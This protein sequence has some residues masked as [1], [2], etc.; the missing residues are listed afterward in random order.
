VT[1]T[2]NFENWCV[3]CIRSRILVEDPIYRIPRSQSPEAFE[4]NYLTSNLFAVANSGSKT[5][6][7]NYLTA[8]MTS[9][10]RDRNRGTPST[11]V[12]G[13]LHTPTAHHRD[14]KD[15]H[16]RGTR[17]AP[18]TNPLRPRNVHHASFGA[19]A[20]RGL[21]VSNAGP[22]T[23]DAY[24]Q[25]HGNHVLSGNNYTYGMGGT[26]S[27]NGRAGHGNR[28]TRQVMPNTTYNRLHSHSNSHEAH[29]S[30]QHT[31]PSSYPPGYVVNY[32][33][34]DDGV[35]SDITYLR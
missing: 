8:T 25:T 22:D 1:V 30:R 28:K 20:D 3:K 6:L 17:S 24:R 16:L 31:T 12:S 9:F 27:S 23:R 33:D 18:H 32:N 21:L 5:K 35:L 29:N 13:P 7:P 34:R 2:F 15:G 4:A 14:V 10:K 19:S 11:K 26:S